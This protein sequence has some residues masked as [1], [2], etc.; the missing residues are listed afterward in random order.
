[1]K[2]DDIEKIDEQIQS[3][4]DTEKR[5]KNKKEKNEEI[6]EDVI[7]TDTK[8]VDTIDEI[9]I[10]DEEKTKEVNTIENIEEPVDKK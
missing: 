6:I 7:S 1:M 4:K 8:K 3:I 5:I 9:K 10:D 2:K